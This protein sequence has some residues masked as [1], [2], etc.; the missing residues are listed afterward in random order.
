M[1]KLAELKESLGL[2]LLTDGMDGARDVSD[3]VVCDLLSF[4]MANGRA[5]MAWV[6]VQTH[7]NVL[8]VASLHDFSCVIVPEGIKVPAETIEKAG[9]EK[10]TVFSSDKTAYQLCR[11][12]SALGI[13]D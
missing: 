4:V 12:M 3:A 5:G 11:G 6:T 13:G 8:A 7:I 10:I 2:T 1:A 9:E